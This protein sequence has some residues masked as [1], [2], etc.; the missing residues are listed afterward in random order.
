LMGRRHL[1]SVIRESTDWHI[2]RSNHADNIVASFLTLNYALFP[3]VTC[4]TR[5]LVLQP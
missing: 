3:H 1:R 4:S 2:P 5:L